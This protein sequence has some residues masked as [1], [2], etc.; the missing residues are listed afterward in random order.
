MAKHPE[1]EVS[2]APQLD[3]SRAFKLR[4]LKLASLPI[5]WTGAITSFGLVRREQEISDLENGV[6]EWN[7][8]T[9]RHADL[10]RFVVDSRVSKQ[11]QILDVGCGMGWLIRRL[12]EAG[13][14]NIQGCDWTQRSFENFDYRRTDLNQDGLR[15]YE[16]ASLD[17]VTCSDV[18]EHMENPS[19]LLREI[20]R[21][22]RPGGAAFITVPNHQNF[23]ERLAFLFTGNSTRFRTES[24][25]EFGHI[26]LLT[27]DILSSLLKRA[28]LSLKEKRGGYAYYYGKFWGNLRSPLFSYNLMYRI[29][30]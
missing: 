16:T 4:M 2:Q 26:S 9:R 25:G 20:S 14:L 30:H 8:Q 13:F 17:C 12:K 7:P 23:F 3:P 6:A 21:V 22:L 19:F 29:E 27:S 24:P 11:A 5:L 18:I 28:G 15:A 1:H 10:V